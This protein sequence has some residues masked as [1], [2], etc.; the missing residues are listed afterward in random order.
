ML[1]RKKRKEIQRLIDAF[2]KEVNKF[3]NIKF[4]LYYIKN[5][6]LNCRRFEQ[7]HQ[8]VML[9][10]YYG[11][12]DNDGINDFG[13]NAE[14]SNLKWGIRGAEVTCLAVLEGKACQLFVRMA[15][16]AGSILS[17]K[18]KNIVKFQVVK[19]LHE[20]TLKKSNNI[21]VAS[22]T[23]DSNLSIWLNYLL[24][25]ISKNNPDIDKYTKIEPDVFSLSLLTLEELLQE[26]KIKKVDKSFRKINDINFKVALS[27]PGE[28][29]VFVSKVAKYLRKKLNPD[30]L[31]YD[32]DYQSQLARPN[33]DLLLQKLYS[34]QSDLI[35]VFLCSEYNQKEW[36]GLEWRVV[37]DIIKNKNFEKIMLIRFDNSDIESLFS[38]DGYID[39]NNFSE[40]EIS[41]LILERVHLNK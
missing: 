26:P 8:V 33:L 20:N 29:R 4:N 36:C 27:F 22:I 38:T 28:K 25:R 7:Q 41:K 39:A 10:Q 13:E 2:E 32:F 15:T 34:E 24:Y 37:K 23:K 31:F 35:V 17:K 6:E 14:T 11:S 9:W 21:K 18:E 1:L 16:Q 5:K 19:E 3:H 40:K 12:L 30:E